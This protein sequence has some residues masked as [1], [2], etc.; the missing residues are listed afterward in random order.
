MAYT[1]AATQT[2]TT[3]AP[4]HADFYTVPS[5]ATPA[6][7]SII[8][9]FISIIYILLGALLIDFLNRGGELLVPMQAIYPFDDNNDDDDDVDNDDDD[10]DDDDEENKGRY[11]PPSQYKTLATGKWRKNEARFQKLK[12]YFHPDDDKMFELLSHEDE[13]IGQGTSA[14]ELF[15]RAYGI[16]NTVGATIGSH[17]MAF[18]AGRGST[19]IVVFDSDGTM[20]HCD[21][22]DVGIPKNESTVDQ[23][24]RQSCYNQ[25]INDIAQQF[26]ITHV[27]FC[28]SMFHLI[29]NTDA[30]VV[31]DGTELPQLEDIPTMEAF[32]P[33]YGFGEAIK[34]AR[35]L[36]IRNVKMPKRNSGGD[37]GDVFESPMYKT[38]FISGYDPVIDLGT[39]KMAL[40][41]GETGQQIINVDI[42]DW[43][44]DDNAL[45][46]I[47]E[48]IANQES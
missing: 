36:V 27:M 40:V 21:M 22:L 13:A 26:E 5:H 44:N 38:S 4:I 33:Y 17:F 3:F 14:F 47:A 19:Q 45:E 1:H 6:P 8:M 48:L 46:L 30:P 41:D 31:K 15:K 10:S 7:P 34:N 35:A 39:G 29:K 32:I 42:G 20:K 24:N 11:L 9:L 28:D 37:E 25:V 43:E 18:I 23:M 12:S 16:E 2:N